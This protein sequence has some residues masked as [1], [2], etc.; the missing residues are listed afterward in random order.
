MPNHKVSTN[1]YI[2]KMYRC[3]VEPDFAKRPYCNY[4]CVD[5]SIMWRVQDKI[6]AL[7]I[8]HRIVYWSI[9]HTRFT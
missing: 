2:V 8:S 1:V 9:E 7:Q 5:S 4:I 3:P 6:I